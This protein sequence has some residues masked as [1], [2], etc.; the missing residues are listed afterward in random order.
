M[1]LTFLGAAGEVTGSSFLL[2]TS[3]ARV[4]L[5]FGL[6]QGGPGAEVANRRRLP[7]DFARLDAVVLSHAHIDHCGRLPLLPRAGC[8]A[9]VWCTPATADLAGILLADSAHVQQQDAQ[10]WGRKRGE[11]GRQARSRPRRGHGADPTESARAALAPGPL[12]EMPDV[13]SVLEQFRTLRYGKERQVADG[14]S[15]RLHDAGHILGS[16]IVD[17]RVQDGSRTLR[18][19]F[20]GDVGGTHQPLLRDA[21]TP[22]GADVLLMEST[23]GDRNHRPPEQTREELLQ[24][25]VAAHASGGK[26]LVPAFA[27][28]RTQQI[29]YELGEFQRAGRLPRMPVFVDSPMAITTT[30]LYRRHRELFDEEALALVE[31]GETPLDFEGLSFCRTQAQSMELNDLRGPAVIIAASGMLNGGR[32]VHHLKH[33]AG[34]PA[35]HI[36]IVGYQAR[37]TPGRAL[38]DGARE[39]RLMGESLRVN[40]TVHTLG[41]FSAH[42]GR[43]ELLAW[44]APLAPVA[45][46]TFLVH[47]E[48]P[49]R[50]ALASRLF[51]D[52]RLA[53]ASPGA[54]QSVTL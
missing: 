50:A 48:D 24:V 21:V 41:G 29:L 15:L 27:V 12:Y 4:L 1:Q 22:D 42:A 31:R 40:A 51:A 47:G 6:H 33:H 20:S 49:A 18:L 45:P 17:L 37:G 53:S 46:R 14:V 32:I 28:G 25:L 38:V 23:Y 43:D 3:R 54:G 7:A 13:V 35:A 9:P 5:D 26:V 19:V 16:A 39:I 30:E 8:R 52:L 11:R 44:A 34:T 36:V 2:Q 10:R